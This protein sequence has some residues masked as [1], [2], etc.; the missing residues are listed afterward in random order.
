MAPISKISTYFTQNSAPNKSHLF[1]NPNLKVVKL[2]FK[3]ELDQFGRLKEIVNHAIDNECD[4]ILIIHRNDS[5]LFLEVS[6]LWKAIDKMINE[7][8]HFLS[9]TNDIETNFVY[10]SENLFYASMFHN[11][12][13]FI[14]MKPLFKLILSIKADFG[15]IDEPH[16]LKKV[17]NSIIKIKMTFIPTRDNMG[18]LHKSSSSVRINLII[19][20]RNIESYISTC[21]DSIT[22]QHYTNYRVFFVDD[23]SND[24]SVSLIPKNKNFIVIKNSER[25]FALM[26]ICE[27][28]L[29]FEF[30]NEDIIAIL[31]GDDALAHNYVFSLLSK[32]YQTENC[33]LTYGSYSYFN[34]WQG[35]G[36][37]YTMGEFNNIRGSIWKASHLKTFK[38]KLFKEY[39]RQD[40]N[41]LHMQTS[42][43]QYYK[44]TYDMA[45]MFP[46]LEISG[47]KKC[48][49]INDIIYLYRIYPGND[50]NVDRTQQYSI[51]QELRRKNMF[52]QS[53]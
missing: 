30:G 5:E 35:I 38:Y 42:D 16:M 39:L 18:R 23:C 48:F 31:D 33:L 37:G 22:S 13:A 46:L 19:P 34:S 52:K 53:F 51:E 32:T 2:P 36:E 28:L 50:H 25:K 6:Q 29:S 12:K 45:L 11:L 49:H 15:K 24:E 41:L 47:Y 14:I 8:I 17:F 3:Y 4:I 44:M 7:N 21:C 43:H 1:L 26:N 9:I 40:P 20:F 27:T 10:V